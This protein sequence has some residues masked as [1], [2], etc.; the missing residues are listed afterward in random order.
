MAGDPAQTTLLARVSAQQ[1]T[2]VRR[3]PR[4]RAGARHG[5]SGQ[6]V[7]AVG[8][9][10]VERIYESEVRDAESLATWGAISWRGTTPAGTGVK[11]FTRSG[12]TQ[13]A[14]D[15]WSPWSA[16]YRNPEGEQITSPKAR[17]LQWKIELSG[18]EGRSPV[19]TSVTTAY[20][21]R[22]LRPE[23]ATITIHPAGRGLPE[24][25]LDR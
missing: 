7:P 23:I 6:S 19:V 3:R 13:A 16:A 4:P 25:V 10:G 14:D 8:A 17:Y 1:V 20:L 5:Q 15:T 2:T 11:L 24:T 22:N 21:Q 9:S 12:N 18:A